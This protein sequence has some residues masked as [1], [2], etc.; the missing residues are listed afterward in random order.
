M[1]LRM[2]RIEK[3]KKYFNETRKDSAKY[4]QRLQEIE[5]KLTVIET[6]D[7]FTGTLGESIKNYIKE[8]EKPIIQDILNNIQRVNTQ[9][10][11]VEK[12][13]SDMIDS[14]EKAVIDQIKLKYVM[15]DFKKRYKNSDTIYYT[16]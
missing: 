2:Y 15:E 3:M 10:K 5:E 1:G 7:S 12:G 16:I 8:V 13:F 6:S 4:T 11:A 14:D 9:M